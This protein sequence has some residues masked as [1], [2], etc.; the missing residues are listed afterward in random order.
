M[1][2]VKMMFNDM[3]NHDYSLKIALIIIPILVQTGC[4]GLHMPFTGKKDDQSGRRAA[5]NEVS[6]QDMDSNAYVN[7]GRVVNAERIAQSKNILIIPFKAGVGAEANIDLD[8]TSL[9]IIKGVTDVFDDD[10]YGQPGRFRILTDENSGDAELVMKGYVTEMASPSKMKKWLLFKRGKRLE[11]D[12][13]L[14]DAN[15]GEIVMIFHDRKTASK[16][17][18]TYQAMGRSIGINIGRYI[19]SAVE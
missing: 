13:K 18:T 17:D 4:S 12:G 1:G 16:A 9:M 2:Y 6:L 19:L 3:K 5:T 11:V 8:R 10:Q 7:K 14:M 15:S